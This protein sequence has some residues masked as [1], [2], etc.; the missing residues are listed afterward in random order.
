VL[1]TTTDG[2]IEDATSVA[3]S[4]DGRT[5]YYTTNAGDIERSHIWAV[6]VAGGPPAPAHE[7]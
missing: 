7:R 6:P 3:F 4:A 2:L 1:L 5:M